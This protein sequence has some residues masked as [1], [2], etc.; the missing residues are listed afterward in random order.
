MSKSKI[1]NNILKIALIILF[2]AVPNFVLAQISVNFSP[3]PLFEIS[4]FLPGDIAS[5]KIEITN[6]GDV[7]RDAYIEAVNVSNSDN[8]ASQMKLKILDSSNQE[9]YNDNFANF[10][11]IGPIKLENISTGDT[12]SYILEVSFIEDSDNDY[13]DKNLGFD[14]CVGFAGGNEYCTNEV[15]VS[16]ENE[17]GSGSSG[18]SGSISSFSGGSSL[19]IFNERNQEPIPPETTFITIYWNTNKPATSQVIYGP[20]NQIYILDLNDLP[21]LGYMFATPEDMTK[22]TEHMMI[23]GN[24]TLG[25]TY[26]YR[27]VS[28]ASPPTVSYEHEFTVPASLEVNNI[29]NNSSEIEGEILGVSDSQIPE[30]DNKIKTQEENN[31]AAVA[32]VGEN[33]LWWWLL[34]FA[35]IIYIIWMS[36]RKRQR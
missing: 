1:K 15:D 22:V 18:T 12:G 29:Y 30:D 13:Q 14:I 27:V 19:L 32:E 2:L 3:N 35:I 9:I 23:I 16:D 4:N 5:G 7:D 20:A 36:F 11:N 28:R 33:V 10:L 17:T 31:I 25:Q 8:L 26:K 21:T 34:I 6:S 24:L